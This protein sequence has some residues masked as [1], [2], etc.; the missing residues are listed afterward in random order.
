MITELIR[1]I[2]CIVVFCAISLPV[3]VGLFIYNLADY[4]RNMD[5][6]EGWKR[7]TNETRK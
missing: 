4:I 7:D 5:Y 6:Y 2:T 1:K 3:L